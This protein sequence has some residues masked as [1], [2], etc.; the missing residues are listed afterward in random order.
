MCIRDRIA[1][2]TAAGMGDEDAVL[3]DRIER[4]LRDPATPVAVRVRAGEVLLG[5]ERVRPTVREYVRDRSEDDTFRRDC[6]L[7]VAL[8]YEGRLASADADDRHRILKC[9]LDDSDPVHEHLQRLTLAHARTFAPF[10]ATLVD[11]LDNEPDHRTR[12]YTLNALS[13]IDGL[14]RGE[15][16]DD[17][18][19]QVL[20]RAGGDKSA[21]YEAEWAHDVEPNYQIVAFKG[22][23]CL[24]LGEGAGGAMHWL[25]GLDG[26]VDVGSARFSLS[27]PR[28]GRYSLWARV[29]LDDKC[30]NSFGIR[31][32][33]RPFANFP[34]HANVMGKWHWLHLMHGNQSSVHLKA[35]FH[36]ARLEAWEDGV[37]IDKF[38]LV[39][40]GSTPE[41][42]GIRPTVHWDTSLRS[43][44]SFSLE[45][46]S[47]C[48]GTTQFVVVWV[49]RNS[50]DLGAGT[51]GLKVPEPFEIVGPAGHRVAFAA[52][53]PLC[54]TSF[55]VRLPEG[56][57]AAEG[58]MEA[59]Y[60]D[61]SGQTVRGEFIIGAQLDWLCTGPVGPDDELRGDLLS[62]TNVTDEELVGSWA[63]FPQSGYDAYRRLDFEKAY[64]QLKNVHLFLTTDIV[65]TELQ[66]CLLLLTADDTARVYIDGRLA[67]AQ[68]EGG[69]GEGR[70]VK[71]HI[72]IGPGRRRLFVKLYQAA[73][74]DPLGPGS[75]RHTYNH[76][77]F[78][79]LIR[80][81]RHVPSPTIKGL[82]MSLR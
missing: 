82:P 11:A 74:N 79:L 19:Q 32:D 70:M 81:E 75:A 47:Q 42:L 64:G 57:P 25:K 54:R 30:G 39:P 7:L 45:R 34:D 80:N 14:T 3:D 31:V 35:G 40:A 43:S 48:R 38:A 50:P 61:E 60:T 26:T 24:A 1:A 44:L 65:V 46:Q 49:R 27:V 10:R 66:G 62:K 15:H 29:Y 59:V 9:A 67:I 58:V 53:N 78:K 76:C 4:M 2:I 41:E 21:P 51:V 68:E 6:A 72:R 37:F 16:A 56:V 28:D 36:P 22:E 71:R 20:K 5:R 73:F 33:G 52:G 69:P 77:N 12:R 13:S 8:F 63:R 55:R 18:R 23:T 17:W